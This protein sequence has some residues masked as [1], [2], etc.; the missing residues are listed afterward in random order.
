MAAGIGLIDLIQ[1]NK[2]NV[3]LEIGVSLGSTTEILLRSIPNL[4]LFGV[5]PY[6]YYIDWNGNEIIDNDEYMNT[7]LNAIKPYNERF[8]HIRKTSDDAVLDFENESLDFIFIDGVHTYDQVKKDCENFYP[9]LKKNGLFSGHDYNAI[10]V[11]RN[12]VDDF[13]K[14]VNKDLSFTNNDVWYFFK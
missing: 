5:D 11:V 6:M 10:S 2:F 8:V 9:K 7:M 1:N 14:T 3:G 13:K 4:K 12:A